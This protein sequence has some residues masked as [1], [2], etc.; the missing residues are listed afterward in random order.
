MIRSAA[1]S[2]RSIPNAAAMPAAATR[3]SPIPSPIQPAICAAAR[4]QRPRTRKASSTWAKRVPGRESR[5]RQ[6]TAAAIA[7]PSR[8]SRDRPARELADCR[9]ERE[10]ERQPEQA[11]GAERRGD[12]ARRPD[13]AFVREHTREEREADGAS[14]PGGCDSVDERPGAV[15][16]GRV[17]ARRRPAASRQGRGPAGRRSEERASEGEGG[18]PEPAG[19]GRAEPVDALGDA[20]T[21]QLRQ[22]HD[23]DERGDRPTKRAA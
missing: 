15:A 8:S 13:P 4:G 17:R 14:E 9:A 22:R 23:R 2:G 1:A 20:V 11:D 3:R 12:A 21:E 16:R 18:E 5:A 7:T 10:H 19:L 6:A